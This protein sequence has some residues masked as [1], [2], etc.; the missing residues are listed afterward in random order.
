MAQYIKTEE[1]YKPVNELAEAIPP[2]AP[3]MAD[4][5]GLPGLV[6]APAAGQQDMVLHGDGTWRAVEGG[7]GSGGGLKRAARVVTTENAVSL[8]VTG[9]SVKLPVTI[10]LYNTG[11]ATNV[12]AMLTVNGV[13]QG[14]LGGTI[15]HSY[16]HRPG[17]LFWFAET[18]TSTMNCYMR[19]SNNTFGIVGFGKAPETINTVVIEPA[20]AHDG[21]TK[22]FQSGTI[23]EIYEGVLPNVVV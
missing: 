4:E 7:G 12:G 11:A 9:L 5:D 8:S 15:N 22:Y 2:M 23:I 16:N 13:R 17:V 14:M 21:E 18:E 3:A 20:Y 1:G 10:A 19:L 6:P